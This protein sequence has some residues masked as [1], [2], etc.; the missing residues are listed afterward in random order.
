MD[1][2]VEL[3]RMG[4]G[5]MAGLTSGMTILVLGATGK[6]GRRVVGRL[7]DRGVAVRAA[8]RS[9]ETR[10]DW[11]DSGSWASAVRDVAAVYLIAP[12]EPKLIEPFVDQ[13]VA[14]GVAKFVVLS[15]RGGADGFGEVFGHGMAEAERAVKASGVAWTIIGSN[16]FAQNFDED[17]WYEPLLT[18]R[19]AL[20]TGGVREPFVDVEDVAEVAATLLTEDGYDGR[21]YDL[22][23]PEGLTFDEAVAQIAAASGRTMSHVDVS[24]AEYGAELRAQGYPEDVVEQLN[25]MFD[26]VRAGLLAEPADG[27]RQVLGRDATPFAAYVDRAWRRR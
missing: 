1:I 10:F 22:S 20:P 12:E 9:S 15:G 2:W 27:V 23:G 25:A 3:S 8:S 16:N 17:L 18:G 21:R 4:R 26:L 6:T 13:A 24:P 5:G 7:R 14:A 11:E 19:L